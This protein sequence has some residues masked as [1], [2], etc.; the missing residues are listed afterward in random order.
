MIFFVVLAIAT[1]AAAAAL[2]GRQP[3]TAARWGLAIAVVIAG[4]SHLAAPTPFEQH[5]P[6]W[7][8]A[9]GALV[10]ATGLVE[11]ALGVGLALVG[12]RRRLVGVAGLIPPWDVK[13]GLPPG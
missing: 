4:A 12:S 8:P 5:L 13:E 2:G 9:A 10:A 7:V 6:G 1:A 11:I 3:R